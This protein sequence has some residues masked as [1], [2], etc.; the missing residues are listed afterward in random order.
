[1]FT[2][3]RLSLMVPACQGLVIDSPLV[4]RTSRESIVSGAIRGTFSVKGSMS[5]FVKDCQGVLLSQGPR[6]GSS[7]S[8]IPSVKDHVSGAASGPFVSRTA[9]TPGPDV[10]AVLSALCVCV[11]VCVSVCVCV[12]LCVYVCLCL[13][14]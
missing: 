5:F 8:R 12:F 11:C 2:Y 10:T 9:R 14:V 4:S 3:L 7:M 1:M 6:R 13:C